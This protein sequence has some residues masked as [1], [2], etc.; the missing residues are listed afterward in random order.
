MYY[1]LKTNKYIK[2]KESISL[3]FLYNNFLGRFILKVLISSKISNIYAKYMNSWLSKHKIKRFVKRNNIDMKE[4]KSKNY[5]SFNDFFIRDIKKEN[6]PIENGLI[7]VCDSK[8]SVYKIDKYS[9]F[10]IKN[11]VYDVKELIQKDNIKYKYALIFRLCVDDY[12]HYIFPDDGRVISNKKIN[13]VL[14]TVRPI[15]LEKYKVFHENTREVT[16]LEC[17]NLGKVAYIEVGA[18]FVGKICNKN[19][20]AFKK[21]D[22]KG[23]FEFGGSTVVL[24]VENEININEKIIEN[25]KKGIETIVKMGQNIN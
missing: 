23:H 4:Y 3:K 5:E 22:E 14:H 11:S 12:H 19:K 7:A 25:S 9:T 13:G 6:R 2:N 8:L 17:K 16:F 24:L 21:G 1:D 15:A 10:N 18:M 20:K